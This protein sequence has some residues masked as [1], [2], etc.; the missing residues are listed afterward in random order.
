MLMLN[1]KNAIR[2]ED[3]IIGSILYPLYF[4]FIIIYC[5][6]MGSGVIACVFSSS[7]LFASLGGM[8]RYFYNRNIYLAREQKRIR[9]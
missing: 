8:L 3:G 7:Y 5:I 1:L 2:H 9:Q 4:S 6:S